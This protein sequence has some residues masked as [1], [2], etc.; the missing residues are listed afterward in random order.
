MKTDHRFCRN[1]GMNLEPVARALAEHRTAH[2][3]AA[4][5][6][7]ESAR[8]LPGGLIAGIVVVI[9][10]MLLMAFMPG[11]AF[12]FLG[13]ASALIGLVAA[14]VSALSPPRAR[15][16]ERAELSPDA[17]DE[18]NP[19]TGRLLHEQGFEP[20]PSVTDHTT[21]LLHVERKEPRPR[22]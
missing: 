11:R 14:L 4:R 12:K 6:P 9:F 15:T 2:K 1:C 16:D 17:L 21:E 13:V 20:L 10:G 7:R 8:R 5:I 18:A 22:G 3:A 19:T